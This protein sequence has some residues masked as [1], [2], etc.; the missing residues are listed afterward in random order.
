MNKQ[1]LIAEGKRVADMD[2]GDSSCLFARNKT[3]MR[4]NGGCRCDFP[5]SDY[6]RRSPYDW[7]HYLTTL[8]GLLALELEK[9]E[10]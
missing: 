9:S 7:F 1:E 2:C 5:S 6:R 10:T 8:S 3:G 4:T